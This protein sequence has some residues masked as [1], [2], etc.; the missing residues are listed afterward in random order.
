MRPL[1]NQQKEWDDFLSAA[2]KKAGEVSD[3]FREHLEQYPDTPHLTEAREK[4]IEFLA[5]SA[6]GSPEQLTKLNQVVESQLKDPQLT[7]SSRN[8]MRRHQ[9]VATQD[10]VARE[11]LIRADWR[12]RRLAKRPYSSGT[13]LTDIDFFCEQLLELADVSDYPKSLQLAEEILAIEPKRG[14][15]G[16]VRSGEGEWYYH[17]KA[18]KLKESLSRLGK[19]LELSFTSMDGTTINL[20]GYRGKVVLIDFWATWCPPCRVEACA[21]WTCGTR[22]RPSP[23]R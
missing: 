1:G 20:S 13:A 4:W 19:P 14:Q 3:R 18:R 2:Q 21:S 23:T 22:P 11:E 5:V 8:M 16:L 15:K 10:L 12:E 9:I 7:R 17:S 6:L